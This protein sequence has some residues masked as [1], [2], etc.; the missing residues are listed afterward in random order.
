MPANE[1]Y[2]DL[3]FPKGGIDVSRAAMS[4]PWREGPRKWDGE[5]TRIYTSADGVNVRG[6]DPL[7]TRY[8]GGSR[9]GLARYC[10]TPVISGWIVQHLNTVVGVEEGVATQSSLLGRVV[11]LV[12]VSQ[13]RVF[14][15][16]PAD[17]PNDRVLTEA[18]N[19]SA[20]TPPLNF[21]GV[22]QSSPNNQK[23]YMV[24]GVHY[25]YFVPLTNT[26]ETWTASS[27]TLP[28][29]GSGNTARLIATWRG[30][31]VLSG[32]PEDSQNWFMSAVST[33]VNWNYSPATTSAIQAVAGNNSRLGFIGDT[34]TALMAYNDDV[35]L[36]GGNTSIYAMRGDPMA[37]GELSLVTSAIGVAFGQAFTQ[38]PLGNIYFMS[39]TGAVYGMAP[40]GKPEKISKPIDSLLQD[41]NTGKVAVR[42]EWNERMRGFH[43]FASTLTAATA[44]DRH[45]FWES[46][47]SWWRDSFAD[48]RFNPLASCTID[49]NTPSDRVVLIG[50]WDGYIRS[51]DPNASTDDGKP[52]SWQVWIG[53]ILSKNFDEI[54]L[55]SIQCV[56]AEDSGTVNYE[57]HAG[58]T[59]EQALETPAITRGT[60]S[61]TSGRSAAQLTKVAGHAIYVKLFGTDK[62][63]MESIR[64]AVSGNMSK[65]RRRGPA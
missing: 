52:I 15:A 45:F 61:F 34:I 14:W 9:V 49:G 64:A 65:V 57:V 7:T 35:L 60:G 28:V 3:H 53:P 27:G 25:R 43:V 22:M 36:F 2:Q 46:G 40:G 23:L 37:G 33:P 8:R 17:D 54:V 21:T 31:T 59:P 5:P 4:Q 51:F 1:Q 12:A 38:D 39:N 56:L 55:K 47:N 11:T 30:R 63:A 44:S 58:R 6:F 13:G 48:K 41:I 18:T 20:T 19:N 24:D 29:D 10:P 62:F 26:V 16:L 50:S 32:L 42:L